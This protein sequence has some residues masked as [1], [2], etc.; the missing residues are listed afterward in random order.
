MAKKNEYEIKDGN[1]YFNNK[2]LI[3][4]TDIKIN[5]YNL[6]IE[7]NILYY[8]FSSTLFLEHA[9]FIVTLDD[10]KEYK[11]KLVK[12]DEECYYYSDS[13]ELIN[14]N[15][16]EFNLCV[17]DLKIKCKLN[18]LNFSRL[19]NSR[20]SF[21]KHNGYRL[22]H[23]NHAIFINSKEKLLFF[24][25]VLV[26]LLRRKEFYISF[27]YLLYYLTK[28]FMKK[29]VWLISDREE[30]GGDNGEALF[31][32]ICSNK[33]KKNVYFC[34]NKNS[35]DLERLKSVGKVVYFGTLKFYLLYLN[36]EFMISSHA[37][38]FVTSP[39]GWKQIY[40]SN[41]NERKF[42]FLQHGVTIGDLS[43]WLKKSNKNIS[44]LTSCCIKEYDSFLNGNYMYDENVVKLT[45][46]ARFDKLKEDNVK[47]QNLIL[48]APT[49]RHNLVGE[50]LPGT[51]FRE[52]NE[53]FKYSEY[54]KFYSSLINNK[55]LLKSLKENNYKI[56]FCLH[57]SFKSQID[58]FKSNDLIEI[59][60]LVDYSYLFKSAKLLIT[61][62]SSVAFDFAYLK[63]PVIYSQFDKDKF[64]VSHTYTSGCIF[65][66][67]NDGFGDILYGVND[68]VNRTIE[69]I[70]NDC[71]MPLKYKNRVT[72]Y[73]KYTDN[74][75][76][77]RIY[78][79]I[80]K[81]SKK[82]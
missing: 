12:K 64:E 63:K 72:S 34:L 50:C 18:F 57:P 62:Y 35:K 78:N 47:L 44:L 33:K 38:S 15:K 7:N 71:K 5:I 32:Y 14:I 22:T 56:L 6:Y 55:K 37:D 28:P 59:K 70:K 20:Y 75:N 31:N 8:E 40:F 27:I 49:W 17:S 82:K 4:N 39:F 68:V 42:I 25:Y 66:F 80:I 69:L 10:V 1:L 81:L 26:L 46:F 36:C 19:N 23:R 76:C 11:C 9:Y 77:E 73:F 52:Y 79:E 13:I 43:G 24:K 48:L 61:D 16:I 58:D 67:E 74:K 65:N 51:Q 45:G 41:I 54:F 3:K 29:D 60:T 53:N 30:V 2:I 21:Y